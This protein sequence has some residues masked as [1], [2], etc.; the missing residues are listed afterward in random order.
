MSKDLAAVVQFVELVGGAGGAG[1]GRVV[2][3]QQRPDA[4]VGRRGRPDAAALVQLVELLAAAAH[5]RLLH[6]AGAGQ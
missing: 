2:A 5:G 1:F 6:F 3:V 4:V